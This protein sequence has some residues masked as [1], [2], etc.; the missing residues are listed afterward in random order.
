VGDSAR[1][2]SV[3]LF[4]DMLAEIRAFGQGLAIVEQIPSKIVPEA[5]KNT[6]LKI[7][8]RLAAKDDRDSLG[9]AMNFTEAQKRYVTLL[10]VDKPRD[11]IAGRVNFVLFEEGLEQPLLLHL[12]LSSSVGPESR[13]FEEFF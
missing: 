1:G 9:A 8:L 13:P 5:V 2:K 3:G 4:V 10:K 12:P 7:M 6:S 11:D